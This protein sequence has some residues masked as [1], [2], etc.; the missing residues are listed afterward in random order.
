MHDDEKICMAILINVSSRSTS[1]RN[2]FVNVCTS[3]YSSS[4]PLMLLLMRSS[5]RV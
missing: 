1:P 3:S 4:F 5:P 2:W